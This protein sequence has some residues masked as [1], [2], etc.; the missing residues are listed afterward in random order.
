MVNPTS[1]IVVKYESYLSAHHFRTLLWNILLGIEVSLI[2]ISYHIIWHSFRSDLISLYLLSGLS[3]S[4]FSW[5][6]ER[7]WFTII[8]PMISDPFSTLSYLSQ[9]PLWWLAGGIGYVFG[10]VLS[11]IFFPID[12][13]EVPIKIYF[14]VGT[15]AGILSRLTMQ[16]RVYRILL[17]IKQGN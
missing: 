9:L 15:F 16:V 7:F 11:K 13:Y 12:F 14:F 10:I 4:F 17:S 3:I 1:D 2:L 8:S 5:S 6:A